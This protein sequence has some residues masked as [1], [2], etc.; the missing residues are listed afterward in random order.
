MSRRALLLAPVALFV[1]TAIAIAMVKFVLSGLGSIL[2]DRF[3]HYQPVDA[4]GEPLPQWSET[5]EGVRFSM[6][7]LSLSISG[8][9]SICLEI[10]NDSDKEVVLLGGEVL[11]YGRTIEAKVH[12]SPQD[13]LAR[14]A[15]IGQSK[16]VGLSWEFGTWLDQVLGHEITW[17]WKVRIGKA[18][19]SLRIP[20]QRK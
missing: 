9:A 11:T 13:V 6:R 4:K 10:A 15:P 5:I 12:D 1:F 16:V 20:M 3:C 8:G 18:E 14:T 17:V 19:H 7:P 2:G